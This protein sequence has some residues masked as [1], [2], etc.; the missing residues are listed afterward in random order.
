MLMLQKSVDKWSK[1]LTSINT[2][3]QFTFV[4]QT[5]NANENHACKNRDK[6]SA[7]GKPVS[8]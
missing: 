2:S 7:N 6:L 5:L 8:S 1:I 3:S 4:F